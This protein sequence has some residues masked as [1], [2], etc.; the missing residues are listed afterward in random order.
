MKI[1]QFD[2]VEAEQKN[3]PASLSRSCQRVVD[4]QRNHNNWISK[5]LNEREGALRLEARLV[6]QDFLLI[7]AYQNILQLIAVHLLLAY[8]N[9]LVIGATNQPTKAKRSFPSLHLPYSLIPIPKPC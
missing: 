7:A 4:A 2:R 9:F 1:T 8:T 3:K 5:R 6:I